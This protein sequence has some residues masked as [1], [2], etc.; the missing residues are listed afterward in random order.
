MQD[1]NRSKYELLLH[2]IMI[3][4]KCRR[5]GT[6][7][8]IAMAVNNSLMTLMKMHVFVLNLPFPWRKESLMR[9]RRQTGTL[10]TDELV[11][12]CLMSP[13]N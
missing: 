11:A 3:V 10:T 5:P 2:C 6:Y 9:Q 7:Y 8:S 12:W 1:E 4:T 13:T